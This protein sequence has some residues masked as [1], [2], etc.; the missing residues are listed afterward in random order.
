MKIT[1]IKPMPYKPRNCP[2]INLFAGNRRRLSPRSSFRMKTGRYFCIGTPMILTSA[3]KRRRPLFRIGRLRRHLVRPPSFYGRLFRRRSGFIHM[4]RLS[5]SDKVVCCTQ[6][7][8][9]TSK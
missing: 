4:L 2:I 3:R 1:D 5:D 9:I 6:E 7:Q 8:D